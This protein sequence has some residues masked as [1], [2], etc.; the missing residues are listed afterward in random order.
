[1]L[2]DRCRAARAP[3][4]RLA[5]IRWRP[6]K[7]PAARSATRASQRARRAEPTTQ[8]VASQCDDAAGCRLLAWQGSSRSFPRRRRVRAP[9]S[10]PGSPRNGGRVRSS[11]ARPRSLANEARL[12]GGR[13]RHGPPWRG[14]NR[15]FR[16]SPVRRRV[17]RGTPPT[18][19]FSV[20]VLPTP[21]CRR[22]CSSARSSASAASRS[23]E[24]P[25]R[26]RRLEP[27]PSVRYR[28]AHTGL[29]STARFLSSKT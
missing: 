2:G 15:A 18:S 8:T 14:A 21:F 23:E 5:V 12:G 17:G 28:Y 1:L 9:A 16:S 25:P 10:A 27:G 24:K 19:S 3:S 29:P 20:S 13:R 11:S 6:R 26:C 7:V 4:T 22:R